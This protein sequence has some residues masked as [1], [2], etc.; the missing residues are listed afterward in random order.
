MRN[1]LFGIPFGLQNL[2]YNL[3][4]ITSTG[5]N[6]VSG[7]QASYLRQLLTFDRPYKLKD[8]AE[9]GTFYPIIHEA[10]IKILKETL[11][12][13]RLTII[14]DASKRFEVDWFAV[15]VRYVSETYK[16]KIILLYFVRESEKNMSGVVVE[17]HIEDALQRAE[18]EEE[19][20]NCG[21]SDGAAYNIKFNRETIHLMVAFL[22]YNHLIDNCVKNLGRG[23]V[24]SLTSIWIKCSRQSQ[25][26]GTVF[27][28]VFGESIVRGCTTRWH[29]NMG[30]R[31]QLMKFIDQL[32]GFIRDVCPTCSLGGINVKH[33]TN[34]V[35]NP[36]RWRTLKDELPQVTEIGELVEITSRK[37]EGDGFIALKTFDL[38]EKLKEDLTERS[39]ESAITNQ[40]LTNL[41]KRVFH[42]DKKY[43]LSYLL[44]ASIRIFD[45][46]FVF[47]HKEDVPELFD[48]WA[49]R[50]VNAPE[51]PGYMRRIQLNPYINECNSV[52]EAMIKEGWMGMTYDERIREAW[53]R[54]AKTEGISLFLKF[55]KII[56]AYTSTSA[57][58]ERVFSIFKNLKNAQQGETFDDRME[59]DML[60][61]VRETLDDEFEIRTRKKRNSVKIQLNEQTEDEGSDEEWKMGDY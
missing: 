47:S 39:E 20:L 38:M 14:H 17:K 5:A 15:L 2:A 1:F 27:E 41:N 10:E 49:R 7:H 57:A 33:M 35:N 34:I 45:P 50:D 53:I 4:T 25:R 28:E 24:D 12:G 16:V 43:Y 3:M 36:A 51:N 23:E 44:L 21:I 54:I 19:Y 30:V 56:L 48:S 59:A 8:E 6:G 31:R 29:G 32:P 61:K 9:F 60:K 46:F 22:C 37:I 42:E 55:S 11:K 52:V 18:I 13:R 40:V 58:V 26:F